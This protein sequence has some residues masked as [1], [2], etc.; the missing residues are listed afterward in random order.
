MLTVKKMKYIIPIFALFV[1]I[2]GVTRICIWAELE[3]RNVF[4]ICFALVA[5]FLS[6]LLFGIYFKEDKKKD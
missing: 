1:A 6:G 4:F 2:F 5:T 3:S